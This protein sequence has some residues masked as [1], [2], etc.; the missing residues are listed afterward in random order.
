[1]LVEMMI[2][3]VMYSVM[4]ID[5]FARSTESKNL[6]RNLQRKERILPQ[7]IFQKFIDPQKYSRKEICLPISIFESLALT[8]KK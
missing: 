2:R 3:L 6:V 4:Y 1:M 5:T 8:W 7:S